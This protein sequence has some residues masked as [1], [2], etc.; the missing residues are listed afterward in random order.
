MLYIIICILNCSW[1]ECANSVQD[2]IPKHSWGLQIT[3]IAS[4]LIPS[5][6]P[7]HTPPPPPPPRISADSYLIIYD[8]LVSSHLS[9]PAYTWT[10]WQNP[11]KLLLRQITCIHT[12]W[13]VVESSK[14]VNIFLSLDLI[15]SAPHWYMVLHNKTM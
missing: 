4:H 3:S 10:V 15:I 13:D 7:P 6:P 8:I 9:R 1:P 2:I 11:A 5:S 12:S 14:D